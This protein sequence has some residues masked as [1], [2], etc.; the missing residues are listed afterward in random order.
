MERV[1]VAIVGGGP[2]GAC[3]AERAAAHGAET[4]LFEQ[5]V[6]RE[7]RDELGPDST[8]AAGMLDYWIDIM[9]FDYREIPDDVIHQELE[10]TEFVGPSNRLELT[11]TGMEA[12][13]PRF[14]YT[15][16]RARMD[17]WLHER[18]ANAGADLRVGT[19]VKSLET[20]LR[21]S[22]PK[23]PTHT[24]T[25]SDGDQLEAQYV[26][27]ADGPQ[28][29]ITLDA[30][31]QFTPP[32]RS[33][34]DH[35]SPPEANHIAY[36]EYREFPPELFEEDRLKFWWGYMPGETAYP[37]VFPNDGT[38]ARV[39]LTM[40]IGMTLEDVSD[41]A[42]Y[43]LLEPAD[44]Q[45]PSGAEYIRRLLEQEYGDEYDIEEDIP[46]V[47]DRGKSRGTETYPISSTRPIDSPVGANIAV[48]G[49]AMGTT[50]AFHEGGYH[51]AVRT[52]KIAGRLAA[53]DS[54]ENY[55]EVWKR[56]IGDEIIRNVAFA[57]IVAEYEPDDWDQAFEVINGMQGSGTDTAI[58]EQ[59]Y[60]AG[61]GA[62]RLLAAYKKRKFSYRDGRYVQLSED[63]YF[64]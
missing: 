49:G 37:W 29:R 39:G 44:D 52:G 60:S 9:D 17:D 14:G 48:A 57:D 51:V 30:L 55:N 6:P 62:T 32:G 1:D 25:L 18:A 7:D 15:F 31:D 23:G 59:T 3:A 10:A 26:V 61:I 54:L 20:D 47:E 35:L 24:L 2:A 21:A 46:I 38:V 34:S 4:V 22:S 64:Y 58:L 28:R 27:L 5:G 43:A 8:D 50:S 40:P 19:G 42:S 45:L 63:E 56:A 11:T 12:D 53:T 16:H 36:Q 13:Y 33:V 41:P